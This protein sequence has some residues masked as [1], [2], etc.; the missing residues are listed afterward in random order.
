MNR[1]QTTFPRR[2]SG[3]HAPASR[4]TLTAALLG[5]TVLSTSFLVILAAFKLA[6]WVWAG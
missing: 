2:I 4:V 5:A 6:L 1:T 3:I